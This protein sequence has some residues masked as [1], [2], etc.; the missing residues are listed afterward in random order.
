MEHLIETFI[1]E[2]TYHALSEDERE[3]LREHATKLTW[4]VRASTQARHL[5]VRLSRDCPPELLRKL[6]L[7]PEGERCNDDERTL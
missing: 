2:A 7:S 5:Y 1:P 4:F 3:Q 6:G